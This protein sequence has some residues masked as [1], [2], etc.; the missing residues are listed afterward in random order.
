MRRNLEVEPFALSVYI[1]MCSIVS[2]CDCKLSPSV[3]V[4]SEPAHSIFSRSHITHTHSDAI[5]RGLASTVAP[6]APSSAAT[7]C[8]ALGR[9]TRGHLGPSDGN[10]CF[11]NRFHGVPQGLSRHQVTWYVHV[12]L[13]T[14]S[15]HTALTAALP[16]TPPRPWLLIVYYLSLSTSRTVLFLIRCASPRCLS[17]PPQPMDDVCAYGYCSSRSE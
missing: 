13:L 17:T 3:G 11:V 14:I 1:F 5:H 2:P 4:V 6:P 9:H 7:C 12:P 16:Y 15:S 8:S 10:I